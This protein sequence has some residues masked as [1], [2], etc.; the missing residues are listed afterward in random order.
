MRHTYVMH[1]ARIKN[2]EC[3]LCVDKEK[4]VKCGAW[5]YI[6]FIS[7]IRPAYC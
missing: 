2:E 6:R 3:V 5:S 7:D 4:R 1:T